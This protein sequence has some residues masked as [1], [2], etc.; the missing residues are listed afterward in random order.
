MKPLA[1]IIHHNVDFRLSLTTARCFDCSREKDALLS[2]VGQRVI[3]SNIDSLWAGVSSLTT[4]EVTRL[5]PHDIQE[6]GCGKQK[7]LISSLCLQINTFESLQ[8]PMGLDLHTFA[9]LISAF[10]QIAKQ[11]INPKGTSTVVS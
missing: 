3:I 5:G 7:D 11:I 10:D 4:Q 2:F 8:L 6:I 9:M 1:R